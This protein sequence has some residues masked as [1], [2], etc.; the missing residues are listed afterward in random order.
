MTGHQQRDE[1]IAPQ[2]KQPAV[3]TPL[4]ALVRALARQAA[5]EVFA[6]AASLNRQVQQHE[7]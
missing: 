5:R 4:R 3:A 6:S 2:G 1:A 7:R